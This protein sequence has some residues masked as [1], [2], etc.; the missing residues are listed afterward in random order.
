MSNS[1]SLPYPLC[2][3]NTILTTETLNTYY[4][5]LNGHKQSPYGV[6]QLFDE[7]DEI[8]FCYDFSKAQNS[9]L[10]IA[11]LSGLKELKSHINEQITD[12]PYRYVYEGKLK[13]CVDLMD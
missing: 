4:D 2:M 1:A 13:L 11:T 7:E 9:W 5:T 12:P 6:L 10:P 3:K 8:V